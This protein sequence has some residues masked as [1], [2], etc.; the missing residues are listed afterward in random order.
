VPL[1]LIDKNLESDYEF[2]R[3]G[4]E[5]GQ[6]QIEVLK[7]GED[8]GNQNAP[9][10]SPSFFKAFFAGASA[11]L[12]HRHGAAFMMHSCGSVRD[13]LPIFIEDI[14]LDVLD[15]CQ[16]EPRGMAPEGLKRDFGKDITFCGMLSLQKTFPFGSADDCR[17]EAEH[18]IRT[19][20]KSG[21]YSFSSGNS[22][23]KDIPLAN[24]LAAYEVALGRSLQ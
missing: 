17:R 7:I 24:I 19:I 18:R 1:A 6:G 14:G 3:R 4:L 15:V 2:F 13:L 16:P 22:L 20:G 9:I 21:G 12:A 8:C 5:A 11:A 23:T 10:F